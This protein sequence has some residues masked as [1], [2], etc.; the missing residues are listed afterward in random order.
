MVGELTPDMTDRPNDAPR[1]ELEPTSAP[2][3]TDDALTTSELAEESPDLSDAQLRTATD[4][5]EDELEAAAVGESMTDDIDA[6]LDANS[7]APIGR[8]ADA[9]GS[10]PVHDP[11][12]A[13]DAEEAGDAQQAGDAQEPGDD[14][15]ALDADDDA[16][17]A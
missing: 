7:R 16:G 13:G 1:D 15:L 9:A 2:P 8:A 4:A 12:A 3:P 11:G 10:D 17:G 5:A 14:E 6:A